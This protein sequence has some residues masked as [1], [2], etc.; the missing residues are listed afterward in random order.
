MQ[1]GDVSDQ[2]LVLPGLKREPTL[3]LDRMGLR[4]TLLESLDQTTG[5]I[6]R[7]QNVGN[8]NESYEQAF[9]LLARPETRYAF[10]LSQESD[11]LRD[12][13]GR[14]RSGQACLLARRLVEAGVPLT[15]VFFNQSVRGQDTDP[16]KS[17]AYGWDTHNDIFSALREQLLPRFDLAFSALIEDLESRGLLDETLVICMGEFGRA[18]KV[19]LEPNFVGSSPGRKHWSSVY[20]VLLAG[21]G[22]RPGKVVGASNKYGAYPAS[23]PYAPGDLLATLFSALGID[24]RG[25]VTDPT[26]RP[27]PIAT[28]QPIEPLYTG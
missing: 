3:T 25:H 20:S 15:T 9:Q 6:D 14:N 8:L 18:P 2:K 24:P 13:Y 23:R 1:L 12:R 27:F 21:A 26:D 16:D 7:E 28:G 19:A 22:I 11:E 17:D 10:D 5:L 4:K